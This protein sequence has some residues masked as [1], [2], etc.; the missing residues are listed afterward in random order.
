MSWQR[1]VILAL[2]GLASTTGCRTLDDYGRVYTSAQEEPLVESLDQLRARQGRSRAQRER[3]LGGTDAEAL[4]RCEVLRGQLVHGRRAAAGQ[5]LFV[6]G[7]PVA[8]P[9][10]LVTLF[11]WPWNETKT[12]LQVE[13]A[14]V[15]LERAYQTDTQSFLRVCAEIRRSPVGRAFTEAI[16]PDGEGGSSSF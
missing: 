2:L 4:E 3:M 9:V 12:A 6:W 7:C 8:W 1:A 5:R 11:M 16:G 10:G 13:D 14:A 15:A